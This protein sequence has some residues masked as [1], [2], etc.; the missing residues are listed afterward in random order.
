MLAPEELA[1]DNAI[2]PLGLLAEQTLRADFT[3]IL[4][5][6]SLADFARYTSQSDAE[7]AQVPAS[8]YT[9]APIIGKLNERSTAPVGYENRIKIH[10][11]WRHSGEYLDA[12]VAIGLVFKKKLIALAAAGVTRT[13]DICIAE[14]QA[15]S[16]VLEQEYK[17][18]LYGG[19][20]WTDTLVLGWE[21]VARKLGI[22]NSQIL[23]ARD[24]QWWG[25][26]EDLDLRLRIKYDRT[27]KRLGYSIGALG[28]WERS[29]ATP[30][31]R[32]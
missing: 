24:T 10:D 17:A 15:A 16:A 1:A 12:G 6:L 28:I 32:G 13:G 20:R 23:P 9:L 5:G 31:R 4:G 8:E 18:G 21:E 3:S 14:L 27:A 19:M 30:A 11:A 22:D 29:L 25:A 26:S 2:T 7:Q